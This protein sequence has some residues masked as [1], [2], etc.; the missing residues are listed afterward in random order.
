MR[1]NLLLGAFTA[2]GFLFG[3]HAIAQDTHMKCGNPE[4]LK[5]LH[6]EN[7]G[8]EADYQ[9]MINKY[10]QNKTVHG[11]AYTEITIPIVFH[12]IHEYGSENITDNQVISQVAI[13]NRDYHKLNADTAD[14][15]P[16]FD[17]IIG[18]AN[19][20]FVLAGLDPY[21][22]CTNG[23]EH[24]YN[25]NTNQGDDF[26]KLNQWHRDKYLNV[27][28]TKSIG[29][30]GVAGYA[31]YPTSTVGSF[32]FADGIIILHDYIGDQGTGNA[33]RS[34]ALTHEIGH[35]LG[36]AHTWGNDNDPGVATSCNQDDGIDDTPN[37]IGQTTCNLS[38]NTC[39]D[40]LPTPSPYWNFDAIDN[41]QNYMEYSY[42]SNMFTN[43]QVDLMRLNMNSPAGFRNNLPTPENLTVTGTNVIAPI[44]KP[45]ADFSISNNLI[46]Q[47]DQ[48]TYKNATWNATVDTYSWSFP[49]GTPSTS[50]AISPTVTYSDYGWYTATLTVT[51]AAGTSTKTFQNVVYVSG[52]WTENYGPK[53]E[54]FNS[55]VVG[56]IGLN[57]ENNW[58][59]FQ[60]T[61]NKG[62]NGSGGFMLNNYKNVE[63][64]ETYSDDYYYYSRLGNSKDY[65]VSPSFNLSNTSTASV[66]FDYSY[67]T[68][69]TTA[70]AITEKLIVSSSNDCGKSW[71]PRIT[72]TG[73][74]L[75][76]AG[77]VGNSNYAPTSDLQ[78]KTA[79]F[80]V[81]TSGTSTRTRFRFEF[82]ASDGSSNLFIDNVNVNGTLGIE[83][84]GL[85]AG[86]E[87]SPN[88]V[89]EGSDLSIQVINNAIG[90]TL[91]VMDVNGAIITT[92]KVAASNGTETVT[93]PMNVA[94]G[95][96][97]VNAIQG[98]AKSTHRV[99]VY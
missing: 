37:C 33:F 51:N 53:S 70:A 42:C 64:A 18:N 85:N 91:Q 6:A 82:T 90:T 60:Y 8:M 36:L 74:A 79:T 93:I 97:F 31:Y 76:S 41:V 92:V 4:A 22:N 35:Y 16:Q 32:F 17:S 87:L 77:Y 86:I 29:A 19:I 20:K 68:K 73:Q 28:V 96:Y 45:I 67:G 50:T 44:C 39:N 12:I 66:S 30:S 5:K 21:G 99:V 11:K 58:A 57:P 65:L 47:G 46:C 24:I 25:H 84:N 40:L 61:S 83:E 2:F 23:I 88:P 78:W 56:W 38:A 15:I 34:R 71:T 49:G 27:W 63:G 54:N 81:P 10:R 13:L 3:S 62:R 1:K 89:N 48:V 9:K 14:V 98:A 69:S 59:S 95:C 72:L 80:N 7:P 43:Q 94:K 52:T 55:P 75:A 26:S